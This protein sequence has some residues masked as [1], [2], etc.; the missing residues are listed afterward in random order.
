MN[1]YLGK[2]QSVIKPWVKFELVVEQSK[3]FDLTKSINIDTCTVLF[4]DLQPY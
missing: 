4:D 2:H 3:N 1:I